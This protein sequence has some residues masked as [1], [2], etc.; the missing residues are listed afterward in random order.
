MVP[1]PAING[2]TAS[3]NGDTTNATMNSTMNQHQWQHEHQCRHEALRARTAPSPA[4]MTLAAMT[5]RAALVQPRSKHLSCACARGEFSS[6]C[7]PQG[8]CSLHRDTD[9][10]CSAHRKV[11]DNADDSGKQMKEETRQ[12]AWRSALS[13][14]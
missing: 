1:T 12:V 13:R 3:A 4:W 7:S 2:S 11:D 10:H 8:F 5:Q 6:S 9:S 14:R